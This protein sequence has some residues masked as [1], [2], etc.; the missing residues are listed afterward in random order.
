M[1]IKPKISP[2]LAKS[3]FPPRW[4]SGTTSSTT[5]K[6]IAPAANARAYGKIGYTEITIAAPI[7]AKIGS[8]I[9]WKWPSDKGGGDLW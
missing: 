2:I 6:I 4:L 7:T 5:I 9:A 3:A 8:T 1:T